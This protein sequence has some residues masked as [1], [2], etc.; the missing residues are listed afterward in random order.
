MF[1][2]ARNAWSSY[3]GAPALIVAMAVVCIIGMAAIVLAAGPMDGPVPPPGQKAENTP[4]PSEISCLTVSI[5]GKDFYRLLPRA[6]PV[7]SKGEI[8]S[9]FVRVGQEWTLFG[10]ELEKLKGARLIQAGLEQDY[11]VGRLCY[12]WLA[13]CAPECTGMGCATIRVPG[14]R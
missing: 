2:K 3:R 11:S 4:A 5:D 14:I 10:S 1:E 9:A 8:R 7:T 13:R 12:V 6:I